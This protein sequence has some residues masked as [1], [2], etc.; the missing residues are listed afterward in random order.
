MI[1]CIDIKSSPVEVS[2]KFRKHKIYLNIYNI[3]YV[4]NE[5]HHPMKHYNNIEP[6]KTFDNGY[7]DHI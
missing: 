6:L 2:Q 7:F 3:Q 4:H 5:R 1:S